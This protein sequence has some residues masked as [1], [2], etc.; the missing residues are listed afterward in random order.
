LKKEFSKLNCEIVGVSPD[1]CDKHKKFIEKNNLKITLLCDPE[2]LMINKYGVW[3]K[4]K[5]YGREYM[6]LIRSTFLIDPNGKVI[7]EWKNVR[8]K[9][10]AEKVLK[11]LKEAQE[12]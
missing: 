6:G 8:A 2:H 7:K 1:T 9:G 10:H 3:Q 11:F 4:K 12:K 5:N